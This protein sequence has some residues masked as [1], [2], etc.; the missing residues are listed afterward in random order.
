VKML[1]VFLVGLCAHA[2]FPRFKVEQAIKY[3]W[4][5]PTALAFVGL[6]VIMVMK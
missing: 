6:V 1:V 4:K 3:L 2:V 5:W